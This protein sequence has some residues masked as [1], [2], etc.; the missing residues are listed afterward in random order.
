[1]QKILGCLELAGCQFWRL[2][3]LCRKKIFAIHQEH[4]NGYSRFLHGGD[5]ASITFGPKAEGAQIA[6]GA[7]YANATPGVLGFAHWVVGL[8]SH[9]SNVVEV[10]MA[11]MNIL[12]WLTRLFPWFCSIKAWRKARRFE[13]TGWKACHVRGCCTHCCSGD[14]CWEV[15]IIILFWEWVLRR[16]LGF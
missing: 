11:S 14:C 12:P 7:N 6:S 5:P 9:I 8:P 2:Q 4:T 16:F 1:M 3:S 13:R 15:R 10:L